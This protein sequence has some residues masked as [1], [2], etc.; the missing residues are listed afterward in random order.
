VNTYDF[1]ERMSTTTKPTDLAL[2]DLAVAMNEHHHAAEKAANAS[3]QHAVAAGRL[4]VEAKAKVEHGEFGAWVKANFT[5]SYPTARLYMQV[6][7]R[8]HELEQNDN[9]VSNLSLREAR[10][11]L[12]GPGGNRALSLTG[13][14]EWYTP[15]ETV[16]AA[17][18]AMGGIDLDPASC[19]FA[20]ETVQAPQF[21]TADD[22]GL[23]KPWTGNVFLNP[24]FKMPLIAQF[25]EKL[26]DEYEAGNV[27]QA[28][29][30]T[31]N[32]TDAKW[33]HRALSVACVVCFTKGRLP[34][35]DASGI[36]PAPTHGQTLF[37][38]GPHKGDFAAAFNSIGL[39]VPVTFFSREP[40]A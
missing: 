26:C 4:L 29:L 32:G 12:A 25:V 21:Y 6:A 30:L 15:A 34:F 14:V 10:T 1:H 8:W 13:K 24:P 37:Y 2:P 7:N 39:C 9:G 35:Y 22:D 27:D 3:L 31:N 40:A 5:G 23:A 20:N 33:W 28:V 16:E 11:L 36:G 38:F 19:E 17:R 18:R